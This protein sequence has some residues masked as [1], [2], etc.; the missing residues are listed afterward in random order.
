[1]GTATLVTVPQSEWEYSLIDRRFMRMPH[2]KTAVLFVAALRFASA[3]PATAIGQEQYVQNSPSKGAFLLVQNGVAATIYVDPGDYTGVKRAANDLE[4]DVTR[5]SGVTPAVSQNERKLGGSVVI[6]GTIGKSALIDRLIREGKLSV[7]DITGKWESTLVQVVAH[8]TKGIERALVIVGSDKRGAIFGIYDLSEQIGVSPW[9][10]WAD[11]PVEHQ[12]ALYVKAGRYVHGEPGVK[13]RGIFLNDEAPALTGWVNEKYGGYNHEF[14]VKVFELL[15]RLRANFLWPA[16]W[17]SAFSD[18]DALNPK[19]ADEYGI[20]MSTSHEEPMMR[21]E[22]EWTR[23][24]HGAWDYATNA[25]EIDEFWRAGIARN[26]DYENVVTLGMRGANDTAMSASTNT[27]LLEKVVTDQRRILSDVISPNLSSVPQVWALYKE[28]QTYYEQGMRVPE[29]VTLLWCD[30]NWGNI[31]RLPT[32]EERKRPG[33]AGIYY[34][35][36]YVGGPRSYKWIN[37]NPLPKIWQQMSLARAYGADRIWVVN[38]GD[39]KPME[40]PIEFFLALARDPDRW[41]KDS[42]DEFARLWA[43]REFGEEHATEI[44]RL[45]ER[46]AKYN[47]RRKPELLDP[48]TFSV[49]NYIEADRVYADWRELAEQAERISRE[50]PAD[51]RDAFFELV[52]YPVKASAIVNELYITAG[53]NRLYA[54]QGRTS[55]NDLAKQARA[56]FQEDAKLSDQYNHTLLNGKWNHMMDQ[57]HIGYTSWNEPPLNAMPAVSEVQPAAVPRMGVAVEDGSYARAP[58]PFDGFAQQTRFIDVFNQ[59]IGS[60]D[61]TATA[62]QPWIVF[63]PTNGTVTEDAGLAVRIDWAKAP[64]GRSAGTI[65]IAQ[66]NGAVTQVRVEAFNPGNPSRD[67]VDAFVESDHVV[68][69]EAEHFT[70]QNSVAGVHWDKIPDYGATL[71]AMTIFP[72]D[73][74]SVEPPATSPMLEYRM[75]L[76]DSGEFNVEAILAPTLNYVPGRGV[77]FAIAFDDQAPRVIDALVGSTQK[78]WEQSVSDGVRKVQTTLNLAEP[79][80]HTL[81]FSMVDAGVVLEKIVVS[82]GALKPSY[83]GPPESFC[84]QC[85]FG[86]SKN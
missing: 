36:D 7:G 44:A 51:R 61:F 27:E 40:F 14:Y 58:L 64:T 5:V 50:L 78:D 69:I 63:T 84:G 75:Y 86:A 76:F 49:L 12:A 60:F 37:T 57:T 23:G 71:S 45:M 48:W 24:G 85:T 74:P 16:M 20:V 68:S 29:D 39:L 2:I 46:Y 10:W 35:F 19:L 54:A 55:T 70:R 6:I 65:T 80:W 4:Q 66:R 62:D 47:G 8:P 67:S 18:D 38:V 13:Y 11:V 72:I 73:A 32:G 41:G 42:L 83:L 59:G 53:K 56:L 22:K 15:L 9:Y 34:H 30:D 82:Q 3:P 81:K 31:R 25:K 52:L 1:M 77:R 79:G 33:G 28:V 26:K 21:A 43:A 17:N